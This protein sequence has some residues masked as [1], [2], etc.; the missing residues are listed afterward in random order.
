MVNTYNLY[1]IVEDIKN[2]KYKNIAKAGSSSC[3]DIDDDYVLVVHNNPSSSEKFK[4]FSKKTMGESKCICTVVDYIEDEKKNVYELQKKGKG[5]HFRIDST[6]QDVY[7]MLKRTY[8]QVEMLLDKYKSG[9]SS[10]SLDS[11]NSYRE[12]QEKKYKRIIDSSEFKQRIETRKDELTRRYELL[13]NMPNKHIKEFLESVLLLRDNKLEYDSSGNNVL[14]DSENGF[15]II[16]LT[17]CSKRTDL[18]GDI[19]TILD[20]SDYQVANILLGV[21]FLKASNLNEDNELKELFNAALKKIFVSAFDLEHNGQ[22]MNKEIIE[23][24]LDSYKKFGIDLTYEEVEKE[25]KKGQGL[26]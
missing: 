2:G 5:E 22:K 11:I 9:D 21:N 26:N 24:S 4:Q 16:D 18:K 13:L 19:T 12:S 14:Y 10:L 3:Y 7:D 17:D 25:Y 20:S 8:K 6:K 23:K 1:K 15:S